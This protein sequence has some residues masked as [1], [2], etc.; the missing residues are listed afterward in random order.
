MFNSLEKES[1]SKSKAANFYMFDAWDFDREEPYNHLV[2]RTRDN[3]EYDK[4][5][6]MLKE[7]SD[8]NEITHARIID[9]KTGNTTYY[10]SKL[11]IITLEEWT[12]LQNRHK[13]HFI[14][15][16]S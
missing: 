1:T 6:M 16:N 12:V 8:D 2:S 14:L 4:Y 5:F 3:S 15:G 7:V 13:I 10:D 9:Y 11:N